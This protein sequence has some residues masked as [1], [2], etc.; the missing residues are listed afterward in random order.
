MNRCKSVV[1]PDEMLSTCNCAVGVITLIKNC[2]FSNER[3]REL[4]HHGN[5]RYVN[6][7][8]D[9]TRESSKCNYA[10][11]NCRFSNSNNWNEL[12]ASLSQRSIFSAAFCLFLCENWWNVN[13]LR[14]NPSRF[15]PERA[16]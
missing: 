10:D 9:E 15:G 4:L 12:S 5:W 2:H 6:G 14:V 3:Q 1:I 8:L 11:G 13:T 7:Y 16:K